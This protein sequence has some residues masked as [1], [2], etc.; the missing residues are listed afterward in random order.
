MTATG[1]AGLTQ[2]LRAALGVPESLSE[3]RKNTMGK[4]GSVL[5]LHL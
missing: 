3:T 1:P 2:M 5:A 4:D